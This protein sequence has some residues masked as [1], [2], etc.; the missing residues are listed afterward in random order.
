[1]VN[2][3]YDR[4]LASYG[5]ELVPAAFVAMKHVLTRSDD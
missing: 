1:M 3:A 2:V 5:D 4:D